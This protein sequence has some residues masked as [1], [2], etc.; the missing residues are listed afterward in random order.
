MPVVVKKNTLAGLSV[1]EII[2]KQVVRLH[3]ERSLEQ[4]IT[5]MRKH[6]INTV[7][8]TDDNMRPAGVV[9]KTDIIGAYYASLPVDSPLDYIMSSPPVFC[10][11]DDLLEKA[12]DQ[13]RSHKIHGLYI[14]GKV[15]EEIVGILTYSD[16]VGLLYHYCHKC[17]LSKFRA[18][19]EEHNGVPIERYKAKEVMS[20]QVVSFGP[21][22][23]LSEIMEALS[24]C[25]FGA[26]LIKDDNNIPSGM[27]SKT[28]LVLSFQK[29]IPPEAPAK[30]IMST[31]VVSCEEDEYLEIAIQKMILAEVQRLFVYKEELETI[32]GVLSLSDTARLRSGSCHACMTSRIRVEKHG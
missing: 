2:R 17:K 27:V 1:G 10:R 24:A 11:S 5:L 18:A 15:P 22:D 9:S 3:R 31:H 7:L 32:T 16:I 25:R 6:K 23:S 12:L 30:K 21:D 19:K 28:D 29:G 20:S 26:V 8:V 14:A 4:A 13:M